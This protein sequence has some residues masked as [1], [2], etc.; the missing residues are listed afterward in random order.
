M[1][2]VCCDLI[3][4]LGGSRAVPSQTTLNAV[5]AVSAVESTVQD[6]AAEGILESWALE[7]HQQSSKPCPTLPLM[8]WANSLTCLCHSFLTY[9]WEYGYLL[10]TVGVRS[11][12]IHVQQFGQ[13]LAH[14]KPPVNVS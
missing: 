5:A 12:L 9:E 3:C 4:Q 2:Q 7:G 6:E 13:Y 8:H 10:P 14:S 1:K 11:K